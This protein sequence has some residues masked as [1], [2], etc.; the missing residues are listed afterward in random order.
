MF[1]Q[2][3]GKTNENSNLNESELQKDEADDVFLS[4]GDAFLEILDRLPLR[5]VLSM[6]FLSQRHRTYVLNNPLLWKRRYEA[7]FEAVPKIEGRQPRSLYTLFQQT[8]ENQY[9]T[10]NKK[11]K[12]LFSELKETLRNGIPKIEKHLAEIIQTKL[13]EPQHEVFYRWV[14]QLQVQTQTLLD[15]LFEAMKE[16]SAPADRLGDKKNLLHCAVLTNQRAAIVLN[17]VQ[18]GY[19]LNDRDA[20]GHT[21]LALA[22]QYNNV[23]LMPHLL[24]KKDDLDKQPHLLV[25]TIKNKSIEAAEILIKAGLNPNLTMKDQASPLFLAAQEGCLEIADALIKYGAEIDKP[26]GPQGVTPLHIAINKNQPQ[27]V[28]L[29]LNAGANRHT[30]LKNG[31]SA[32]QLAAKKPEILALLKAQKRDQ[33]PTYN[34]NQFYQQAADNRS[35]LT[36][37]YYSHSPSG[38]LQ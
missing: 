11:Q 7:H 18:A 32:L 30:T 4:F 3:Y 26:F 14:L 1:I 2:K 12:V 20:K 9:A 27:L 22:V 16:G 15:G 17:L 5:D 34:Q 13:H 23:H 6:S 33:Q 24:P 35:Q 21:P 28:Q 31:T 10:L 36:S 38:L 19:S 37:E 25:Y 29:L 8:Y